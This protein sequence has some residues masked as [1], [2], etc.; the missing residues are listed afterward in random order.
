MDT[1]G[2]PGRCRRGAAAKE[3]EKGVRAPERS[4]AAPGAALALEGKQE[5][6]GDNS[7]R[8]SVLL[9][10]N[11]APP[12]FLSAFTGTMARNGSPII[13]MSVL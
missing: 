9:G 12:V 7:S 4:E 11:S 1:E 10:T 3:S 2:K 8:L 6:P 5:C 13:V